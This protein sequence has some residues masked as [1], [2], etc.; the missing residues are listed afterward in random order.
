MGRNVFHTILQWV[1]PQ[2]V[3]CYFCGRELKKEENGLLCNDC[4]RAF[5]GYEQAKD[6]IRFG[7]ID[8]FSCFHYDE[9]IRKVVLHAKDDGMSHLTQLMAFC[10]AQTAEKNGLQF[11]V[12][13]YVPSSKK[14]K[15]SR[16]YDHMRLTA[17]E[18]S[19]IS[20]KPVLKGLK[21]VK[22]GA[23]QAELAEEERATNV[24][25]AFSYDG[26]SLEN[27]T[28]LLIDDVVTTGATLRSCADAL[29]KAQPKS[30]LFCT[31]SR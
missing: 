2:N 4:K 22:E 11:D 21:R 15:R 29:R 19:A 20:D 17:R 18:L 8:V 26:E 31:F 1:Y 28:V 16:G 5:E 30:V 23:D 13:A 3:T 25:D 10:I 7:E 24:R 9:E 6:P 14:K 12:I 27:K